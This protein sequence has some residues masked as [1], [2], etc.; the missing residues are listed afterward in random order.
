MGK[1]LGFLLDTLVNLIFLC[2]GFYCEPTIPILG[3][4]VP[5]PLVCLGINVL[6]I[7]LF[8]LYIFAKKLLNS[9]WKKFI[10]ELKKEL[11]IV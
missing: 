9:L 6:L 11:N 8:V 5:W 7:A 4:V 1:I 10:K 2:I 3:V